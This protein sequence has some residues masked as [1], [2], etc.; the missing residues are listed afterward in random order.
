[1]KVAVLGAG[2]AGLTAAHRL[3]MQGH[4]CD[5]YERWPGLGGEAATV[6]TG[7][8][9]LLERYYHHL[10]TSDKEIHDLCDEIG[11]P[12]ELEAW[13]STVA[14]FAEGKLH[15]FTSPKDLLTY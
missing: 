7:D 14:M 11:L 10:F 13:P 9:V 1:M 15:P 8:G 2:F 5:V 6:D 4:E 12:D 3:A